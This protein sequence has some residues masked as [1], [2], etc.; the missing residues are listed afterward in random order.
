MGAPSESKAVALQVAPEPGPAPLLAVALEVASALPGAVEGQ[1]GADRVAGD[2]H[3][4][5][6]RVDLPGVPGG[7]S[8]GRIAAEQRPALS[9]DGDTERF[10]A[11]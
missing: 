9:I 1:A 2:R 3:E 10:R 6:G 8:A 7:G 5:E 4:L 11:A